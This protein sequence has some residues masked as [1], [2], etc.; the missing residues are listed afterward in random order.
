MGAGLKLSW[1]RVPGPALWPC[2]PGRAWLCGGGA[3]GA[4]APRP[5]APRRPARWHPRSSGR[6]ACP[7][8]GA[9]RGVRAQPPASIFW[10]AL[11]PDSQVR[12]RHGARGKRAG[13]GAEP[14]KC[15]GARAS[16]GRGGGEAGAGGQRSHSAAAAAERSVRSSQR[17]QVPASRPTRLGCRGAAGSDAHLGLGTVAPPLPRSANPG[18]FLTL[19]DRDEILVRHQAPGIELDV[20]RQGPAPRGCSLGLLLL[21]QPSVCLSVG[22]I[23]QQSAFR[24]FF[25]G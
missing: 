21:L 19:P 24:H 17:P 8:P 22:T 20:Q 15:A 6:R 16:P 2:S 25:A 1:A 23:Q 9:D 13:G 3:G 18:C 7:A 5:A 11:R 12:K 10:A 14:R 4:G